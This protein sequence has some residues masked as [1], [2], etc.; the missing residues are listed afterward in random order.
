MSLANARQLF[1][2]FNFDVA[3]DGGGTAKFSSFGPLRMNISFSVYREAG[4][5]LPIKDP[6]EVDFEN[7]TLTRGAS[8]SRLFY[9]WANSVAMMTVGLT[10]GAMIVP[11]RYTKTITIYQKDRK[12]QTIQKYYLHDAFPVECVAGDWDNNKDE[13]VFERLVL[14]YR[15]YVV[16]DV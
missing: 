14:T 9:D 8:K 11:Q 5:L 6:N 10:N 3:I 7:V 2:G 12:K 4:S 15:Y 16:S 13:A 1:E